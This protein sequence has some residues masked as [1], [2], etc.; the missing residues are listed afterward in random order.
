MKTQYRLQDLSYSEII[1][2]YYDFY[3]NYNT[4][5][6][7]SIWI[8]RSEGK[9]MSSVGLAELCRSEDTETDFNS[10]STL[11]QGP[12]FRLQL[13]SNEWNYTENVIY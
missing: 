8:K 1:I 2:I 10:K 3:F 13:Y 5:L 12:L 11:F 9:P 4:C 7:I 6:F